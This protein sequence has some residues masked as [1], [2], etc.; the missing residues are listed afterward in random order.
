[1]K[2]ILGF[3][4]IPETFTEGS[5]LPAVE[6]QATKKENKIIT[7]TI[8]KLD[9]LISFCLVIIILKNSDI[10]VIV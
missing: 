2:M 3:S 9:E 4:G 1:M 6:L 5:F 8:N 10:I 7:Q